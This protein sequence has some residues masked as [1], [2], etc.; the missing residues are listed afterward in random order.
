[1]DLAPE[2]HM[3]QLHIQQHIIT[4]ISDEK[5]ISPDMP[6]IWQILHKFGR[7]ET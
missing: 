5:K 7:I 3:Q 4:V 2:Q 1:V 6:Q